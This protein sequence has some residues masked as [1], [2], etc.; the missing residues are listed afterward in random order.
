M[1]RVFSSRRA[2]PGSGCASATTAGA[3]AVAAAERED[4]VGLVPYAIRNEEGRV[5]MGRWVLSLVFGLAACSSSNGSD[6][7][8]GGNGATNGGSAGNA[9]SSGGIANGGGS[10]NGGAGSPGGGSANSG[11]NAGGTSSGGASGVFTSTLVNAP[12]Q[13][14][15]SVLLAQ[16]TPDGLMFTADAN[17]QFDT[18]RGAWDGCTRNQIGQCWYYD[19][20]AG[21]NPVGATDVPPVY[22]DGGTVSVTSTSGMLNPTFDPDTGRYNASLAS[23]LW[24]LAGG[25]VTV[26]VSG[27][28]NVPA[29]TLQV[30]A[31]PTVSLKSI[32]GEA[33]PASIM[34]S[35]GA[36]LV[37]TSDG[38]GTAFFAIF[39][40]TGERPAAICQFDAAANAGELPAA[41]LEQL[42]AGAMY[43]TEFRGNS[44]ADVMTG[45]WDMSGS[46][47]AFGANPGAIETSIE[48]K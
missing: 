11:S 10:A 48:L 13:L 20:P 1:S 5:G 22:Y 8:S 30:A 24:P 44:V 31:P 2:N 32:N 47:Y 23:Q 3:F 29:F 40:Y 36:K 16:N 41:V 25:P 35:D 6:A 27:G 45:T 26:T 33:M 38:A 17:L 7:G 15:G 9:T 43:L 42:D 18:E 19:C 28:G 21:S 4:I 14:R 12:A 34:R 46:A 39:E 37:W